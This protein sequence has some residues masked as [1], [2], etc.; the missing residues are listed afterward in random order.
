MT[1]IINVDSDSVIEKATSCLEEGES[2][3]SMFQDLIPFTYIIQYPDCLT[4]IEWFC[5]KM[6][7]SYPF[8][9]S[10]TSNLMLFDRL[11]LKAKVRHFKISD[12]VKPKLFDLVNSLRNLDTTPT[13]M[14]HSIS[15]CAA[16]LFAGNPYEDTEDF[17]SKVSVFY[18]I[19]RKMSEI[20]ILDELLSQQLCDLCLSIRLSIVNQIGLDKF[21]KA[22]QRLHSLLLKVAIDIQEKAKLNN[23]KVNI[24]Q[25]S[26]IN[27]KLYLNNSYNE[28]NEVKALGA[29]YSPEAKLWW[30][31]VTSDVS[32][33]LRWM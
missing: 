7:D 12:R 9:L 19:F 16:A 18:T 29:R 20:E 23:L 24:S 28:N 10:D 26:L 1:D 4:I 6:D 11:I 5:S 3:E 31:P 14:G 22:Y 2:I 21:H 33:F 25:I 13:F 30:V 8:L 15:D 17:D 27:E 32:K